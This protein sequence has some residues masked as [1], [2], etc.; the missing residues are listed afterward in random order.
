MSFVKDLGPVAQ[1]V[2]NRKLSAL[3]DSSS[4]QPEQCP[5]YT[6]PQR[7]PDNA[8]TIETN[9]VNLMIRNSRSN[10]FQSSPASEAHPQRKPDNL[11]PTRTNECRSNSDFDLNQSEKS[12]VSAA[13]QRKPDNVDATK[14]NT[15]TFRD[16]ASSSPAFVKLSSHID[17]T[18]DGEDENRTNRIAGFALQATSKTDFGTALGKEKV[19]IGTPAR[20]GIRAQT[21]EKSGNVTA[22]KGKRGRAVTLA[23]HWASVAR[24]RRSKTLRR[25]YR[26]NKGTCSLTDG[27]NPDEM[28]RPVIL[29]L[30][31]PPT[32]ISEYKPRN[33]RAGAALS[34]NAPPSIS[35][36]IVPRPGEKEAVVAE[37]PPQAVV[38]QF[39]FNLA[40]LKERLGQMN[41]AKKVT[42]ENRGTGRR[43]NLTNQPEEVREVNSSQPFMH[44]QLHASS[45]NSQ[46]F[47]HKQ[48]YASSSNN[49]MH[50]QAYAGS[51]NNQPCM[52][53][54]AYA[55]SSLDPN[56]RL[57][58]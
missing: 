43:L 33:K 31:Y 40:F 37:E 8:E 4:Y 15:L 16:F 13:S 54:Q 11:N 44:N 39:A 56:L 42:S 14:T 2:A 38:P 50:N 7:I 32:S 48:A 52:Y 23:S 47:M 55:G 22:R 27:A 36:A 28:A 10:Q 24:N 17:L 30:E 18:R 12:P 29:A 49:R 35:Q 41:G 58:L 57:H 53:N 46:P 6:V 19:Q 1:M 26:S 25:A 21:G 3:S 45:S 9:N 5:V 20:S 51:S 34:L